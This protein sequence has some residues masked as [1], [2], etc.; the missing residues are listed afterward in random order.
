MEKNSGT[1]ALI[2]SDRIAPVY[3]FNSGSKII[4]EPKTGHDIVDFGPQSH[5]A[6]LQ[7][8]RI[9]PT[10]LTMPPLALTLPPHC[11]P[12]GEIAY[13]IEGE[14]FDANLKGSPIRS[15]PAGSL[16]AYGLFSTHRPL[17]RTGA[18]IFYIP[19]NGIVFP[20]RSQEL[21]TDDPHNLVRKMKDLGAPLPALDYAREWMGLEKVA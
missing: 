14:Y 8:S 18:K 1:P 15:Y 6:F 13:V 21:S 19:F 10:L 2:D 3:F 4:P 7:G 20:S 12:G 5:L 17:S 11:H 16:V 9:N